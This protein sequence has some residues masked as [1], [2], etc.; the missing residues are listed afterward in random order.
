[1]LNFKGE[2]VAQTNM[3][4]FVWFRLGNIFFLV[5]FSIGMLSPIE[6]IKC[7]DNFNLPCLAQMRR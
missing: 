7:F 2:K 1:M 3:Q 4:K 6:K 5:Y